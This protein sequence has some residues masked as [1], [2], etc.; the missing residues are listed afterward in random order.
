MCVHARVSSPSVSVSD[1]VRCENLPYLVCGSALLA[2]RVQDRMA[3]GTGLDKKAEQIMKGSGAAVQLKL[4]P[5]GNVAIR[6]F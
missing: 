1:V 4:C 5:R 6:G 3:A 2:W